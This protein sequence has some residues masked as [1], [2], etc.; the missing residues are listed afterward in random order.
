ME[1]KTVLRILEER[2]NTTWS[3]SKGSENRDYFRI[4][5]DLLLRQ[6]ESIEPV[7]TPELRKIK[8]MG[9]GF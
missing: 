4:L 5:Q 9:V 6:S 8:R 3:Q 2:L 7:F 1:L